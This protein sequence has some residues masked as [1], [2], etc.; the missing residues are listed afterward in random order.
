M[1]QTPVENPPF[2]TWRFH[3]QVWPYEK[4]CALVE[5]NGFERSYDF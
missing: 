1:E 3:S 2:D 4:D 5:L